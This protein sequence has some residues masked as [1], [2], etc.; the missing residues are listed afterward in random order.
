[1]DDNEQSLNK[2]KEIADVLVN[3]H[4]DFLDYPLHG[5][6]KREFPLHFHSIDN[7]W[8]FNTPFFPVTEVDKIASTMI[9][10]PMLDHDTFP[11][12]EFYSEVDK[13]V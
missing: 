6:I 13:H 12:Q 7:C 4:V 2:I 10:S 5:F 11:L 9:N 1:M 3:C 8:E